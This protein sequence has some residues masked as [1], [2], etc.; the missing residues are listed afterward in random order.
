MV[1][2]NMQLPTLFLRK[3][4]RIIFRTDTSLQVGLIAHF[5]FQRTAFQQVSVTQVV[6]GIFISVDLKRLYIDILRTVVSG[7]DRQRVSVFKMQN[8]FLEQRER[9]IH[10]RPY[11]DKPDRSLMRRIHTMPKS[12]RCLHPRNNRPDRVCTCGSSPDAAN[13]ALSGLSDVVIEI[14]HVLYRLVAMCVIAHIHYSHF[15]YFMDDLS[16]VAIIEYR[17]NNEY[18]IEH[19]GKYLFAPIKSTNP[20]GSWNT[21]QE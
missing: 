4:I 1:Q 9:P 12:A 6:F 16:V 11:P 8:G 17:R 13:I 10:I 3:R 20:C 21:D 18:G 5:E 15:A 14:N 7:I 19:I 2:K